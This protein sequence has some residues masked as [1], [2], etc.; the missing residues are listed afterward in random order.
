MGQLRRLGR[1]RGPGR[2]DEEREVVR[3]ALDDR[4]G[5]G[6]E[7]LLEAGATGKVD[8]LRDENVLKR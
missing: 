7:Q 5:L 4:H 6:R 1:A 8:S 2:E 3:F